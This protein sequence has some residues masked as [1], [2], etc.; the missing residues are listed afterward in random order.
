MQVSSWQLLFLKLHLF[1]SKSQSHNIQHD[2]A[3]VISQPSFLLVFHC[4]S[5]ETLATCCPSNLPCSLPLTGSTWNTLLLDIYLIQLHTSFKSWLVAKFL[6]NSSLTA[7]F[8]TTNCADPCTP[9]TTY[10]AWFFL[11]FEMEFCSCHPGW[12][13]MVWSRLTATSAFWFQ[14][15]LLPQPPR[16]LSPHPANFC[17]FSRDGVSPCWPG[18]S[19][20]SNLRWSTWLGLPKCWD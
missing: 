2:L 4:C 3:P 5:P 18:W 12:S 15:F 1:L 13:A 6:N 20:T 11:F 10:P 9:D 14:L 7:L 8:S 17:I 16:C 19:R